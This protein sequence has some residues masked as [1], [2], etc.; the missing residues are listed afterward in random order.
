[1]YR[2]SAGT[3]VQFTHDPVAAA[4][5]NPSSKDNR[6]RPQAHDGSS[7]PRQSEAESCFPSVPASVRRLYLGRTGCLPGQPDRSRS[8]AK[9]RAAV[10][11]SEPWLCTSRPSMDGLLCMASPSARAPPPQTA[12]PR[13]VTPQSG[14]LI[15]SGIH[16]SSVDDDGLGQR[17]GSSQLG[18][19]RQLAKPTPMPDHVSLESPSFPHLIPVF[20]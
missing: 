18:I 13:C 20:F 1:M 16:R 15:P 17:T 19:F 5:G 8:I 4:P 12:Q 7:A 14:S 10:L 11:V 3:A 9:R 2:V 6:K